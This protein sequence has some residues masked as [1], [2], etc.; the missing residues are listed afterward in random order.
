[1]K[2]KR[3]ARREGEKEAGT[4]RKEKE[5]ERKAKEKSKKAKKQRRATKR[6]PSPV[7]TVGLESL[8]IQLDIEDNGQCSSC[9]MVF[10]QEDDN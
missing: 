9:G 1:M 10:S 3:E 6:A 5:K 4:R 8:F 2:G 7:D